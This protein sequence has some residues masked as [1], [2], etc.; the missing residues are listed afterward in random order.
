[1]FKIQ[2][3]KPIPDGAETR[4]I[5]SRLQARVKWLG[6]WAWLPCNGSGKVI[7]S[8]S[9]WYAKIDGK[10]VPLAKDRVTAEK[11]LGEK[12]TRAERVREGISLPE[13][14]TLESLSQLLERWT[15][16]K[17]KQGLNSR[18]AEESTRRVKEALENMAV[19]SI[20]DFRRLTSPR[21][22]SW[23][24]TLKYAPG[25]AG[26]Y[27]VGLQGFGK[28]LKR[29]HLVG[30][31]PAWPRK[32]S[33]VTRPKAPFT[34]EQVTKLV[35][36]AKKD[37]GLFYR[38]AFATISRVGALFSLKARDFYL[39]D[40]SGPWI[41]LRPE[42]AKNKLGQRV[43][44]PPAL[45]KDLK[46]LVDEANGGLVFPEFGPG[47][48]SKRLDID[49]K[50]AGIQKR[51]PDGVLTAHSFRHGGATHL[52]KNGVSPF[53][54]MRLGGWKSMAMLTKH[55]GHVIP[56]DAQEHVA[57]LME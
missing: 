1:V 15:R 20:S 5:K 29:Q 34:K 26:L 42:H 51:S 35:E 46:A 11:I 28:W 50:R 39:D 57:R 36:V 30:E 22:A 23:Y 31:L 13:A 32:S 41:S 37:V 55:Y 21:V 2:I 27:V 25:T 17:K 16:E 54:V 8:S 6:K 40:P 10:N 49:M 56:M 9:K 7:G 12:R 53:Q 43:P 45:A 47:N 4:V 14:K 19:D 24:S 44:L 33:A 18:Y 48:I 38:L 3:L 52:L